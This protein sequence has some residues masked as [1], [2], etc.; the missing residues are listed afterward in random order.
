MVNKTRIGHSEISIVIWITSLMPLI[1][2]WFL[3][4]PMIYIILTFV[5][6]FIGVFAISWLPFFISK[7]RLRPALDKCREN[8]TTWCRVTKDRIIVPQF[9]DKGSYG[10]TKGITHKEKADIVDDGSFGCRWLNGNPAILMYDMMNT[11]IDLKKSVARKKM[12][13]K[14]DVRTG[15]EAYR[16]AVDE[17]EVVF[18]KDKIGD[19]K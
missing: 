13:E 2:T 12:K 14:Y 7:Y 10:Q 11:N 4:P 9:V 1:F 16:K 5:S 15:V 19:K 17:G 8:E 3:N 18:P 6:M